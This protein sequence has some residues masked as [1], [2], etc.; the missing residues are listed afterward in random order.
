[1]FLQPIFGQEPGEAKLLTIDF[2]IPAL[3]FLIIW[4]V[5]LVTAFTARLRK[6]LKGR[7]EEFAESTADSQ[8]LH[9]LFPGVESTCEQISADDQKLT[10]LLNQTTEFRNDLADPTAGFLGSQKG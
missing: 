1:M 4:S 9:G 7:I 8:L 3:I 6:G 10:S 2:Y 5:V